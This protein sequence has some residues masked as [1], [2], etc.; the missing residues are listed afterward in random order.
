MTRVY[1]PDVIRSESCAIEPLAADAEGRQGSLSVLSLMKTAN[2]ESKFGAYGTAPI[3]TSNVAPHISPSFNRDRVPTRLSDSP[4]SCHFLF[5][6]HVCPSPPHG[7]VV[8]N[9][10]FLLE[11]KQK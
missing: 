7:A 9:I 8:K 11:G 3:R 2:N 1:L 4:M 5:M 10:K 6:G